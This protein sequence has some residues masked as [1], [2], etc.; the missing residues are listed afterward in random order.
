MTPDQGC[1]KIA[2]ELQADLALLIRRYESLREMDRRIISALQ[3]Q[4]ND[5]TERSNARL[6]A[7]VALLDERDEQLYRTRYPNGNPYDRGA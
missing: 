2:A 7:L 6:A 5:A 1:A 3:A 4:L